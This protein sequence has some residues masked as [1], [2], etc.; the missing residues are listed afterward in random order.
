MGASLLTFVERNVP[1]SVVRIQID[2]WDQWQARYGHLAAKPM[3][4]VVGQTL[5]NAI[6][7]V[8][9]VG[10]WNESGFLAIIAYCTAEMVENVEALLQKI[11]RSAGIE[12]WGDRLSVSVSVGGASVEPGDSVESILQRA[13]RSLPQGSTKTDRCLQ[14][15]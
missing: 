13:E 4:S 1:F 10:R 8:D 9:M 5:T 2:Q 12:W 15:A 6:R 3:L 14:S 11:V 7:P